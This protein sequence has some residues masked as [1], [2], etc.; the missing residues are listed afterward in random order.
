MDLQ[1]RI[2]IEA[3][4]LLE[5]LKLSYE[6]AGV[7]YSKGDV[8]TKAI[9]DSYSM[10]SEFTEEEWIQLNQLKVSIGDYTQPSKGATRPKLVITND[11]YECLLKLKT[12]ITNALGLRNVTMGVVIK[13]LLKHAFFNDGSEVNSSKRVISVLSCNFAMN[14]ES[15]SGWLDSA[16]PDRIDRIVGYL[17]DDRLGNPDIIV[18]TEFQQYSYLFAN[19]IQTIAPRGQSIADA[20]EKVGYICFYAA[21]EEDREG[22]WIKTFIAVRGF[23]EDSIDI[24]YMP[25]NDDFSGRNWLALTIRND[26]FLN[27]ELRVV[28]V[29]APNVGDRKR[30]AFFESIYQE[31]NSSG[32]TIIIGDFNAFSADDVAY[33]DTA[34]EM[35][36]EELKIL[37]QSGYVDSWSYK[38][39]YKPSR[40]FDRFTYYAM[41]KT[42]NPNVDIAYCVP[43]LSGRRLD[44]AF[45]S[46][47]LAERLMNAEHLHDTRALGLS[48][49]SALI[50]E[51]Y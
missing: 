6:E 19:G 47:D 2:S 3:A 25:H 39:K 17:L 41:N 18:I 31:T 8:V 5:K 32:S 28:G 7:F 21:A 26:S 11:A 44:Y 15:I 13:L 37:L 27:R 30:K 29:H 36:D 48:D 9:D 35:H 38:H 16:V 43:E 42:Y 4:Y 23:P 20:L 34:S 33:R 51:I 14:I 50:L 45:I 1:L 49:H 10:L 22:I 46:P 40:D 12:I 24:S